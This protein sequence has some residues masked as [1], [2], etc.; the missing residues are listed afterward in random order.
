MRKP[1]REHEVYVPISA[2]PAK[3]LVEEAMV[4]LREQ[5]ED[6]E[7][8]TAGRYLFPI[9]RCMVIRPRHTTA[10]AERPA[11]VSGEQGDLLPRKQLRSSKFD[12]LE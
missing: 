11:V 1:L 5:L 7:E 4:L 8:I 9:Q 12:Y 6:D 10:V 2:E 3:L